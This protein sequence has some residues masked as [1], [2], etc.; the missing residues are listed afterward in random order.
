MDY[1]TSL[2]F[3]NFSFFLFLFSFHWYST[4]HSPP[5]AV[6]PVQLPH[7]GEREGGRETDRQTNG[8]GGGGRRKGESIERVKKEGKKGKGVS[9]H[10]NKGER[11]QKRGRGIERGRT[12]GKWKK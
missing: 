7:L 1:C 2:H 3:S 10:T 8:V 9:K 4:S 11:D 5:P 6:L 12:W